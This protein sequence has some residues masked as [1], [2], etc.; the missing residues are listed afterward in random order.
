VHIQK[1]SKTARNFIESS[2]ELISAKGI[3]GTSIRNIASAT[4]MSISNI[5]HYFGNKEGL[6][7]AILK[8]SYEPILT[9]MKEICEVEHD[10]LE[11]LKLLIRTHILDVIEHKREALIASRFMHEVYLSD[12]AQKI[13]KELQ[14][15]IL[16]FYVRQLRPLKQL[17]YL[18]ELDPT[19]VAFNI[20]GIINWF[21]KWYKPEGPLSIEKAIQQILSFVFAAIQKRQ[22]PGN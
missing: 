10:P 19:L 4:G 20:I 14:N 2:I 9:R 3:K 21:T 6:L 5:Y 16:E 8:H 7:I 22:I 1:T 15:T 13:N 11:S 12:K 18:P 17:G